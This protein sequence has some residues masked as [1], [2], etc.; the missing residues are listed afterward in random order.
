MVGSE[1]FIVA[2]GGQKNVK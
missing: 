1:P 2:L